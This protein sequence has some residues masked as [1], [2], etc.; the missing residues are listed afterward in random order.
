MA[1]RTGEIA[2][3]RALRKN[4]VFQTGNSAD[5]RQK[6]IDDKSIDVWLIWNIWQVANRELADVVR[7]DPAHAIYRDAGVALTHYG[8]SKPAAHAFIDFLL[9]TE[10]A[11]IFR[12]WGW[13]A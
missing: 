2:K 5:A 12:R 8:T 6:W 7:I 3:V 13:K 9:S 1:G 4:I 11:A 10:G